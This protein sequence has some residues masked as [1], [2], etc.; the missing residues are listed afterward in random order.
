[1]ATRIKE[2][3]TI[4]DQIKGHFTRNQSWLAKQIGMSEGQ[5]S[6]KIHNKKE[7]SQDE[8]DKINKVL[9]TDFKL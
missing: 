3:R 7:W 1:M 5:L 4:G 6:K 2:K 8:L 9:G